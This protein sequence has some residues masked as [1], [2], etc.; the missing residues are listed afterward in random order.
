MA[1]ARVPVP[2]CSLTTLTT[3]DPYER[4]TTDHWELSGIVESLFGIYAYDVPGPWFTLMR[5]AHEPSANL[6][7]LTSRVVLS[8]PLFWT[9]NGV[10]Q[11]V[12][13]PRVFVMF[14]I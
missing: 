1:S 13:P 5:L 12:G 3:D 11:P 8:V 10:C 14:G 7:Q 4:T 6:Y 9:I 2:W